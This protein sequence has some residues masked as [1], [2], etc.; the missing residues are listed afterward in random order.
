M[1]E[2]VPGVV[3]HLTFS[4]NNKNKLLIAYR[5]VKEEDGT[6]HRF[7]TIEIQCNGKKA[8][9]RDTIEKNWAFL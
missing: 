5:H 9:L 4:S 6:K 7:R 2:Y 1:I 3:T 8:T